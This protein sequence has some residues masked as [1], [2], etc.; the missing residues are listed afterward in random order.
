MVGEG[1]ALEVNGEREQEALMDIPVFAR[2]HTLLFIGHVF[3]CPSN[4]YT[5]VCVSY[6]LY[7]R[8]IV[9]RSL[10]APVTI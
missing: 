4:A 1:G 8:C 2:Q 5:L 3:F 6:A 9:S 7:S 10:S